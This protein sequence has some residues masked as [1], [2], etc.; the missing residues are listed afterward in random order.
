[1][2]DELVAFL[3]ARLD[4]WERLARQAYPVQTGSRDEGQPPEHVSWRRGPGS[5][6]FGLR[7]VEAD[8]ELLARY[9][10]ARKALPGRFKDGFLEGLEQAL[11]IR[12][13]RF[14]SHPDYRSQWGT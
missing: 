13:Q 6:E 11:E 7:Q 4:E 8:R 12:A 9:E 3:N 14:D 1:M 2:G 10:M 5:V